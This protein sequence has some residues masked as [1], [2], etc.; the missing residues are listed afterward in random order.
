VR[1]MAHLLAIALALGGAAGARLSRSLGLIV[2]RNTLLRLI[3]RAPCPVM[4]TPQVLSVDD[5]ALRRRHTYGTLLL[6]LAQRRPLA[7]LPDREAATVAQ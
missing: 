3:R 5:F 6:D 2:S 1:L 4:V 7:L